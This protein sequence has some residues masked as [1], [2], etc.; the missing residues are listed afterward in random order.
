MSVSPHSYITD[1]ERIE[2]EGE[3]TA[4]YNLEYELRSSEFMLK[5]VRECEIYAQ[6]LYCALCNNYFIKHE[7]WELLKQE[8][9]SCSWRHAGGIIADMR[10][11]GDYMDWYCSGIKD[12]YMVPNSTRHYVTEEVVT[13][14]V[15]ND[16]LILGWIIYE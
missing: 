11:E 16:L 10:Q 2:Y 3:D 13:E 9:W 5:K 14:E 12:E 6:N 15:K 4:K 7:F 8:K 1:E